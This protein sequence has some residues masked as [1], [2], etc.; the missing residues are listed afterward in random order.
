MFIKTILLCIVII[1]SISLLINI[2]LCEYITVFIHSIVDGHLSYFRFV[3]LQM[4]VPI[5]SVWA[6]KLL[7]I[8]TNTWYCQPFYICSCGRCVWHLI[9]ILIC[10]SQRTDMG[11]CLFHI[12]HLVFFF[13]EVPLYPLSFFFFFKFRIRVFLLICRNSFYIQYTS[14]LLDFVLKIFFPS[15]LLIFDHFDEQKFLN[16]KVV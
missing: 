8:L 4:Y 5:T 12:S 11:E 15:M 6:F 7:N 1:L 9:A 2:P 10:I 13:C 16:F 14:P 3:L